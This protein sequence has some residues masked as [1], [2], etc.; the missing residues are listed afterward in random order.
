MRPVT[1][2]TLRPICWGSKCFATG[3]RSTSIPMGR[4]QKWELTVHKKNTVEN[5]WTP[6][7]GKQFCPVSSYFLANYHRLR[8]HESA[9]GLS[10][11]EVMV[12][13]HLMDH[14]W[15]SRAPYP[16][17]GRLAERMGLSTRAVRSALQTLQGLGYVQREASP[18]GG[19]N[20]YHLEGL[21]NALEALMDGDVVAR[22]NVESEKPVTSTTVEQAA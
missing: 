3:I 20:K 21:F 13:I 22:D 6:R 14:K 16:T 2:L 1:R 17:L 7:L 11:T 8:P 12:V 5:R 18:S 4:A 19:P 9:Q 15:D 10:S